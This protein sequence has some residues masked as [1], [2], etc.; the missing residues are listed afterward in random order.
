MHE[1]VSVLGSVAAV[2]T[3]FGLGWL[4][5]DVQLRHQRAKM[6]RKRKA[7]ARRK[8]LGQPKLGVT[9]SKGA[10]KEQQR[11]QPWGPFPTQ[12]KPA[13]VRAEEKQGFKL[14]MK[15]DEWLEDT[16]QPEEEA[17]DY[18]EAPAEPVDELSAWRGNRV[19]RNPYAPKKLNDHEIMQA[20]IEP[21]ETDGAQDR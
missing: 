11:M 9:A 12:R 6:R 16:Y 4:L 1:V 14:G 18:N 5:R 21:D 2:L 19:V 7:N 10:R 20:L 17:P 3:A 15:A 13:S 8:A